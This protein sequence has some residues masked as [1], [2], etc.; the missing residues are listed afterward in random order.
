VSV[1]KNF[2]GLCLRA[3]VVSG[4]SAGLACGVQAAEVAKQPNI[5]L[6]SVMAAPPDKADT[7]AAIAPE[8]AYPQPQSD[9]AR[10]V[11][12]AVQADAPNLDDESESTTADKKSKSVRVA[13]MQAIDRAYRE[14]AGATIWVT[15]DG[16]TPRAAA[17]IAT[18]DGS[19]E[20]GLDPS[21][22]PV[23][24]SVFQG[25]DIDALASIEL[26]YSRAA[27]GYARDAHVG[28]FDPVAISDLIDRMS[29]RPAPD[30]VLRQLASTDDVKATLLAFQPK[31]PQ[32]ERLRQL[33]LASRVPEA[34]VS[35]SGPKLKPGTRHPDVA[36]IRLA[37]GVPATGNDDSARETY[38]PALVD[39][40]RAF[41]TNQ[42]MK[43]DGIIG[44]KLRQVLAAGSQAQG[45]TMT[46]DDVD[47]LRAN[48]ERWR[49]LPEELGPFYILNNIP[50]YTT[51]VVKNDVIIHEERI[52]VGK[53]TTPTSLFSKNMSYIE[54][55]P[56]WNVPES[57]KLKELLPALRRGGSSAL[58]RRGLR[59]TV[60]G[61]NLHPSQVRWNRI[62]MRK[63]GI[64]QPPGVSNALGRVKF[65]FPNSH[66]IYM[67][68]TPSKELFE[69]EAR[70]FSHGCVRVRDPQQLAEVILTEVNVIKP[71][72]VAAEFAK[73]ENRQIQLIKPFPVHI[74]YF[75]A[76]VNDDGTVT[77]FPDVYGHDQRTTL[78]LAGRMREIRRQEA[79]PIDPGT[80]ASVAVRVRKRAR[81]VSVAR[82]NGVQTTLS[83]D[84]PA[85][86]ASIA[87]LAEPPRK[88]RAKLVDRPA[89]VREDAPGYDPWAG[90]NE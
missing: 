15:A 22:Y 20:W 57:I 37:L 35:S 73:T 79:V 58:T 9:L 81:A 24:R 86:T 33:W 27:I 42:G 39:A 30:Q 32:F 54:L 59:V 10:A 8:P 3:L 56:Y 47:R 1:R 29:V 75:T 82:I 61:K 71:E 46:G 74:G 77:T 62:D 80:G 19:A 11:L 53:P 44:K 65:M 41:Q 72:T 66:D 49:W 84:Q 60:N 26:A 89:W 63:V 5:A 64:F 18:L 68:D 4:L 28:R 12:K 38:D 6:Q 2:W 48:M 40:I 17:L 34:K 36:L 16:L 76:W 55:N 43:S 52:V 14:R 67:H 87:A 88:R 25:A 90:N 69:Q 23:A 70:A 50:E 83:A 78:A 21:N 51:R 7:A 13:D 31:H 85:E 45:T